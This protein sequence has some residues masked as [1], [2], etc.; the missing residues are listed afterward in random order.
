MPIVIKIHTPSPQN[1][2]DERGEK[3]GLFGEEEVNLTRGILPSIAYCYSIVE[4]VLF[5]MDADWLS[6]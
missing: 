3:S 6:Q 5:Q 1:E 4:I 2:K